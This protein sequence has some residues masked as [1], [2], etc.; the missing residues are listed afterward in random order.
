MYTGTRES[1][2]TYFAQLEAMTGVCKPY[3]LAK[4]LGVHL[5]DATNQMVPSFTLGVIDVDPLTMASAYATWAARGLYCHPRPV[6][7]IDDSAGNTLKK[8]PSSCEQVLPSAVADAVND[9]LRGVQEPGGFGYEAG[10]S[11]D[12]PSAGKTGTINDN[13]A[14]WFIGYTPAL[15]TASMIAG[16]NDKGT[17]ITLNGQTVGGSYIVTAHG[18]TTAGPMWGA[19]MKAIEDLLPN[20][21]FQPP[22]GDEVAGV[23]KPVPDVSGMTVGRARDVLS[24]AGFNP[25]LGGYVYSGYAYGDVAY[26]SPGAGSEF[27]S[28][29]IVTIYQSNGVPA[30]VRHSGGGGHK[31]GG[32][33]D[34]K[35]GG[36]GH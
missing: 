21:D 35:G 19:A 16:A 3:Q 20:D 32:K 5:T 33:G 29:D 11:L 26:T 34:R 15:A 10:I 23:L 8:Y 17:P 6:T 2:N 22:A 24:R 18:S 4:T 30:P 13:K 9:I 14:V 1:V 12:K 27:S 28:G 7:A 25:A 31:G 36:G